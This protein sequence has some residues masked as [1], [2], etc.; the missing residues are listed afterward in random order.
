MEVPNT[1]VT[2]INVTP[3]LVVA[4]SENFSLYTHVQ[5][6][7]YQRVNEVNLVPNFGIMAGVSYGF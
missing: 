6:P 1:G 5:I 2:F 4:A 7:V 3:G